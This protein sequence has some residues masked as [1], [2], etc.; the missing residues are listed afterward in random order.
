MVYL[1]RIKISN[2]LMEFII[3]MEQVNGFFFL[4]RCSFS[5]NV[6]NFSVCNLL[7]RKTCKMKVD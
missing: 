5:L 7:E 6:I 1:A 2:Q 4:I 3:L